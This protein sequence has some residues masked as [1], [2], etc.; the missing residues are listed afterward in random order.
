[1]KE[2]VQSS[3]L[4]TLVAGPVSDSPPVWE[5]YFAQDFPG[6]PLVKNLPSKA[7]DVGSIPGQVTKIPQT[8]GQLS[9][10]AKTKERPECLS[11]TQ[12]R[13]KRKKNIPSTSCFWSCTMGPIFSYNSV[14]TVHSRRNVHPWP[15]FVFTFL[16][17][18]GKP[19][20]IFLVPGFSL[21]SQEQADTLRFACQRQ[22][23]SKEP[24][25]PCDRGMKNKEQEA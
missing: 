1:M 15:N 19:V 25:G 11:K 14:K 17:K 10:C 22:N 20:P 16:Q 13:H 21:T 6:G 23:W 7:G 4:L 8:T 18:F 3:K 12:C 9:P 2:C 5:M 24:K